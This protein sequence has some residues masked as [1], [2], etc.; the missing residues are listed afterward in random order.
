MGPVA[1]ADVLK[2]P[3]DGGLGDSLRAGSRS[4]GW[5]DIQVGE[6]A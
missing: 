6:R 2:E 1:W 5:I 3:T 4:E